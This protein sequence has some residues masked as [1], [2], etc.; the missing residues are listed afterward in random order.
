MRLIHLTDPHLSNLE[1]VK[2]SAL[3]GKR[4]S[5]FASWYKNRRKKYLPAVLDQLCAALKAENA[6]QI[7]L[8]GDLV[9]IG[10]ESEI[11]QAADWLA[12]LGSAS[13]I[14][15]VPGNHDIYASGS[16]AA[17]SDL[18]ADYMFQAGRPIEFPIVRKLGKLTVIGLSSAVVSPIFMASGKLDG[19]QLDKLSGLLQQAA[20]ERQLVC[21]LIHHPPL[22]GM[23]G[24]RK[25]L[26]NAAE[27]QRVLRH[28]PPALIFHG[29]LHRNRD[30]QWHDSRVYCTA[31]ASSISDASYRVIDIG[32]YDEYW[33]MQMKLK[34]VA[35]DKDGQP[36]FLCID[37][38][39]WQLARN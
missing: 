21:L 34:S 30:Q 14:M 35:V 29:H 3:S 25:A 8:T 31:A 32:M 16:A 9:Q 11:K 2:L 23:T 33:S 19:D 24:W 28:H 15:L 13:E 1:G 39:S 26:S 18:W 5:G 7:F 17:V 4:W 22:P 6:D 10:L 27:L 37:T 36:G 12:G 38:Q 20:I